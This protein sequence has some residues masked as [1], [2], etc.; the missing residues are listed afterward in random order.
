MRIAITTI[1]APFVKGG[2]EL[3]A[4]NLKNALREAGHEAEIITMPLMDNPIL[5][6]ENHI[7]AAR[8]LE[9]ERTWAGRADLCIGLKFPAYFIPHSNKVIWI[10]HQHRA[11]Y[12]LFGTEFS[13]MQ[14]DSDGLR[15]RQIVQNADNRYLREAKRIYAN[16]QNVSDRLLSN[17]G[18]QSTPLYHPCPDMDKYY[19]GGYGDYVLMP[20]RIN[21][22][23]RQF[24]AVEAMC[25][26]KSNLNLYIVGKADNPEEKARMLDF[27]RDK[28]ITKKIKFFDY[29]EQDEKLALYAA[30]RAVLFIPFDEDYGYITLEAMSASKAV[31]TASDSGGPLEFVEDGKTGFVVDPSPEAIAHAVDALA[32]SATLAEEFGRAGKRRLRN[33]GISWRHV[34]EELTKK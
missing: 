32:Q 4:E 15:M 28:K 25:H 33:M 24:L 7:V 29:L 21:I 3:H 26:T 27:I 12:E 18:I 19:D 20:S 34:V 11:A 1:Q 6:L 9:I 30:A 8:L 22:T 10:L 16:S 23:K 14:N 13:N 2:A 31:I 5:L 17:N